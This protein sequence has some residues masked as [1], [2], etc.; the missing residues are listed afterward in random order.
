M[1]GCIVG[2]GMAYLAG[3]GMQALLFGLGPGDPVTFG[4]GLAVVGL[5]TL[6]G[7][8]VPAIRAVRI[9]PLIAMRSD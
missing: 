3:R 1:A 6:A 7:A 4:A 8:L 9:S 5:V 2:A